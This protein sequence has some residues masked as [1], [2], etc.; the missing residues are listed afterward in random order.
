MMNIVD[1]IIIVL[2]LFGAAVGFKRGFTR[3]LVSAIGT[4]AIVVLAFFLKN[5]V[6]VFLYEH[7]PFFEFGGVI[8]GVTVLNIALYELLAFIIVVAI[9]GI[10]LKILMVVTSIFEKLLSI[11]IILGI[12]SKILGAVVGAVEWFVIVF[13]GLYILNMP[14]INIKEIN[15]SKLAP[16]ILEKTPILSSTIE[17]TTKVIEEFSSIKENFKDQDVDSK[18]F[19]RETLELFLKYDVVKVESIDKLIKDGKLDIEKAEEI[20]DKYREG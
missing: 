3:S 20:L 16:G 10:V 13:I 11:T 8:K 2:I 7:L 4:L 6:S 14:M 5:P 18:Q 9:L 19:N 1:L 17:N 12:P 15:E